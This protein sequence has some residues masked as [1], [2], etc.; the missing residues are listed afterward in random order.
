MPR[1]LPSAVVLLAFSLPALAA[2]NPDFLKKPDSLELTLK[3]PAK[4][5]TGDPIKFR[6]VFHNGTGRA[7]TLLRPIDGSECGWRKVS[8][9]WE[10]SR[11]GALQKRYGYARCG[12]VNPLT[13][14]DFVTLEAGKSVEIDPAFAARVGEF[15]DVVTPG[16]YTLRVVYR[17]DPNARDKGEGQGVIKAELAERLK[18]LP[19][20][21]VASAPFALKVRALPG[22]VKEARTALEQYSQEYEAALAALRQSNFDD[23]KPPAEQVEKARAREAAAKE[24]LATARAKYERLRKELDAAD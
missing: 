17:F 7:V 23:P 13:L 6:F 2:P 3:G 21:E 14:E 24:R 11:E 19:V 10:V 15:F 4:V 20:L 5:Y 1:L 9:A 12:N 16:T 22:N 8:Y 18:N